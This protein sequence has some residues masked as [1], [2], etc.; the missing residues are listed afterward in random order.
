MLFSRGAAASSTTWTAPATEGTYTLTVAVS[1]THGAKRTVNV[2]A[3][4]QAAAEV[5]FQD[6]AARDI[7]RIGGQVHG[8]HGCI[9]EGFGQQNRQ[10]AR[11]GAQVERAAHALRVRD[12]GGEPI[13]QQ[14]R[15]EGARHDDAL[16]DIE[17]ERAEPGFVR[18]IGGRGALA[19]A[20]AQER[21][22]PNEFVRT[23]LPFELGIEFAQRQFE[24]MQDE[25]GGFIARIVRAM[26]EEKAGA[27]ELR[28]RLAQEH[29]QR[30]RGLVFG[31]Q[32]GSSR[33]SSVCR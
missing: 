16:V 5:V 33:R 29:A 9:R 21:A 32:A 11:A 17:A 7:Q 4:V 28:D 2:T 25:I 12:P 19:H 3:Q 1:D 6:V 13:A 30:Q 22:Q 15:D 10:T 23:Q 18:E 20:P 24:R 14:F 27:L 31:A 8:I 26:A